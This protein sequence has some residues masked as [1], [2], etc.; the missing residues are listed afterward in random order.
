MTSI[1]IV[2]ASP[3]SELKIQLNKNLPGVHIQQMN[4]LD[5]HGIVEII[6][7]NGISYVTA[8]GK[9]L[10]VGELIDMSS[11]HN[12]TR[13]HLEQI[14][15]ANW[16]NE[17]IDSFTLVKGHGERKLVVFTNPDCPF[18]KRFELETLSKL[19]NVTI[20]Y[21][22]YSLPI[23]DSK[24]MQRIVCSDK[25][26]QLLVEYMRGRLVVLPDVSI[27]PQL[28]ILDKMRLLG[29][30]MHVKTLPT[31]VMPDGTI[32]EGI[33]PLNYLESVL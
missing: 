6:T 27:C 18:C 33:A 12:V 22:L 21:I 3:V 20:H 19:N 4:S 28:A 30:K 11:Q 9:Y 10:L 8:D 13:E 16:H 7:D 25:S 23:Y 26:I 5:T 24:N 17:V 29:D 31:V 1:F 15:R 32:I 2:L 14:R